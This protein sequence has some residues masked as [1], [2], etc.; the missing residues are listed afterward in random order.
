MAQAK[1][2]ASSATAGDERVLL[3]TPTGRDAQLLSEQLSRR[4]FAVHVCRDLSE[5]CEQVTRDAG[6]AFVAEEAL[7]DAQSLE[8]IVACINAQPPW[9][10]IPLIVMTESGDMTP[11]SR[12]LGA[13]FQ[14]AGNVT[15]LQRPIRLFTLFSVIDSAL[16]SR[17]RQY[18]VRRLL[19][20]TRR[21]VEQRDQ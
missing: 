7:A 6:A 21:A 20:D 3:L 11:Q 18:Q 15:L 19:D 5:L 2:D 13:V 12:R 8:R 14:T 4:G 17:R 16:K 1:R 10:D 9:S